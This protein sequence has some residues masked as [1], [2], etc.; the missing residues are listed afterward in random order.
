MPRPRTES[1]TLRSTVEQS[2]TSLYKPA[3]TARQYKCIIY[4]T[5]TLW[6]PPPLHIEFVLEF[7]EVQESL[8]LRLTEFPCTCGLFQLGAICHGLL[9]NL[10][11][12]AEDRTGDSSIY[13]RALYHVAIK[14][15]LYRRAVQVYDIPNLCPVTLLC[16]H[17]ISGL[18]LSNHLKY[19]D[20][21]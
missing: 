7:S 12:P 17:Y 20:S 11:V 10:H 21:L 8:E 14:A 1:G 3:C 4:L 16:P 13:S 9:K 5:Y 6:H 19:F 2:T 18:Y 15:G